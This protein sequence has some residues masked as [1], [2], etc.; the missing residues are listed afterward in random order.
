MILRIFVLLLFILSG[1][2]GKMKDHKIEPSDLKKTKHAGIHFLD[3]KVL[4]FK[5]IGGIQIKELSALAY[6]DKTLYALTDKGILIHFDMRIHNNKIKKMDISKI[7]VLK[8]A[9][10]KKLKKAY[11]DSEGLCFL[12]EDL[13]ISFEKKHRVDLYTSSGKKIKNE[14]IHKDIQ[15]IKKYRSKNEGLESVAYNKKYGII[16][17]PEN[18]LHGV[19]EK[20]HI[21]YSK[22]KKWFIPAYGSITAL[23]FMSKHKLM[24]LERKFNIL[25][26]KKEITI[27]SFNLKNSKHK[28]LAKL[29]AKE[30]WNVD[31]FEGLTKVGKNKYLIIS[32]DND[33]FFQETLLVL[34]EVK[35]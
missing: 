32:D 24:I 18:S 4:R 9:N 11:R 28:V 25:R 31:N 34:F 6:K 2:Q 3:A 20:L 27:S 5:N 8:D 16:T 35:D 33:S 19:D 30:G 10:K 22:T 13:L 17:A 23:E 26:R 14:K 21:L 12:G 29:D 7:F 15:E 1:V